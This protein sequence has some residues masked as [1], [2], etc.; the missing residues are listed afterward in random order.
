[1]LMHGQ[2]IALSEKDDLSLAF[3]NFVHSIDTGKIQSESKS[4]YLDLLKKSL[5]P[6]ARPERAPP[7]SFQT[8]AALVVI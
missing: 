7:P 3:C 8:F 5:A 2:L 1:M 6:P 4:E